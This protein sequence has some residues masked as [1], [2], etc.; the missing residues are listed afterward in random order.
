MDTEQLLAV[1]PEDMARALLAR[2]QLLKEQ[3]PTVIRTLEAEEQ[4]LTPKAKKAMENN[5][6]INAKVSDL[7][8]KRNNAQ[9][10]ANELL[11]VVKESRTKLMEVDGMINLDP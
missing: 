10:K 3:L 1:S 2:R 11:K 9:K 5:K 6:I 8:E 4:K 7:K